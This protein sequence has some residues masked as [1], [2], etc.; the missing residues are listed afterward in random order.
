MTNRTRDVAYV[1]QLRRASGRP[2]AASVVLPVYNAAGPALEN[3]LA[4]LRELSRD[5]IEFV[6]VNDG[7]LDATLEQVLQA[8][9]SFHNVVVLS[10]DMNG[11]VARARNAAVAAASGEYIWFIDWDDEWRT[12]ALARMLN[13]ATKN[14]ADIVVC[15]AVTRGL[16][17]DQ[18]VVD[19]IETHSVVSGKEAFVLLLD[20]QIL[21]YLWSKIIR[22]AIIPPDPFPLLRY[23]SDLGGFA[24]LLARAN[25][26]ATIPDILYTHLIRPGSVSSSSSTDVSSKFHCGDIVSRTAQS[27]GDGRSLSQKLRRWQ[28]KRVYVASV[29][30]AVRLGQED[31]TIRRII[32]TVRSEVT[33]GGILRHIRLDP[34]TALKLLVMKALGARYPIV[35]RA[36]RKFIRR[37]PPP[38][39][40][41]RL[42]VMHVSPPFGD[43]T[44][45]VNL[46]TGPQEQAAIHTTLDWKRAFRL[47]VDVLHV[48]WPERLVRA[49][50]PLRRFAKRVAAR[51][52]LIRLRRARVPV[53]RTLHNITP[54]ERG[55]RGERGLLELIDSETAAFIALNR[56]TPVPHG[57]EATV[58]PHPHYADHYVHSAKRQPISGRILYFGLIR[59]YKGLD[60][61]IDAFSNLDDPEAMLRIVG[62]PTPR[63]REIIDD[64]TLKSARISARLDYVPDADLIAEI[65]SASLVVFPYRSMHN[66]GAAIAALSLGRPILIPDNPVNRDL[67]DEVG[68]RWVRTFTGKPRA[69]DL[70][71]GLDDASELLRNQEQPDLSSRTPSESSASHLSVYAA[72][73][74]EVRR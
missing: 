42:R 57:H 50:T 20:G 34:M 25:T 60:V 19:G 13:A 73:I 23:Q 48:H 10:A 59:D 62:S 67:A 33:F 37:T 38:T 26:V 16:N 32:A 9:D 6:I 61:L 66:S 11:G 7:S 54:H 65:E 14:N 15:R 44:S 74:N 68:E 41:T 43:T 1:Q 56:W 24:P 63:W 71:Q 49:H 36:A 45:Y 69:D 35:L 30:T 55:P 12:D 28:Y 52:L 31:D 58:I 70:R 21:G 53:V 18:R 51:L 47:D 4:A 2:I 64:A 29:N 17:G 8:S 46:I 39:P 40:T 5:S 72:A 27:L 3:R 22:R